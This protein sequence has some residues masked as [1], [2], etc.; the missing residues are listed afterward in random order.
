MTLHITSCQ[1]LVRSDLID[2][3]RRM[4]RGDIED[5]LGLESISPG[6][7]DWHLCLEAL[8]IATDAPA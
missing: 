3:L 2:L 4:E 8:R 5:P 6:D 7:Q 1:R